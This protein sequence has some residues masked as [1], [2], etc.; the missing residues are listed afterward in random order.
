MD[1]CRVERSGDLRAAETV[2]ESS[3]V[4]LVE[5]AGDTDEVIREFEESLRSMARRAGGVLRRTE[6][7]V[8]VRAKAD[9]AAAADVATDGITR[10][11]FECTDA[12]TVDAVLQIVAGAVESAGGGIWQ[13]D[14]RLFIAAPVDLSLRPNRWRNGWSGGGLAG[15]RAPRWPHRPTRSGASTLELPTS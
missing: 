2:I 11:E 4:A 6:H 8:V 14:D 7:E 1:R 9:A 10:I 15:D 12:E 3:Q 5:L 13:I